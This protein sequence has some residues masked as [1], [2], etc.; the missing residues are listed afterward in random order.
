MSLALDR[1][2]EPAA[3]A[4]IGDGTMAM[5]K[6]RGHIALWQRGPRPWR[7]AMTPFV[8]HPMLTRLAGA[9]GI[10]AG[11]WLAARQE[12]RHERAMEAV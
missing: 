4:M 12:K 5:L 11:I 1:T 6:P 3:L 7:K 9:A 10:A 2:K 8:R